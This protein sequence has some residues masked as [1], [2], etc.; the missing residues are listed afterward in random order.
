MHAPACADALQTVLEERAR[1]DYTAA[2]I[3]E[4]ASTTKTAAQRLRMGLAALGLARG[5]AGAVESMRR[6]AAER[7]GR[8]ERS[9]RAA[10]GTYGKQSAEWEG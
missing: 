5:A 6:M 4:I 3:R 7:Q 1:L 8:A 10:E 2:T 9:S